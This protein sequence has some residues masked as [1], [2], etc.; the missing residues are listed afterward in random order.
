[1]LAITGSYVAVL[2]CFK[3]KVE[4]MPEKVETLTVTILK[5]FTII[6]IFM[7]RLKMT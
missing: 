7:E 5:L 6:F 3:F 4:L 2:F 1:M